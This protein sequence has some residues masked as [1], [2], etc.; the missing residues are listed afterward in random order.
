MGALGPTGDLGT[1]VDHPFIDFRSQFG[2]LRGRGTSLERTEKEKKVQ[3]PPKGPYTTNAGDTGINQPAI[4][5]SPIAKDDIIANPPIEGVRAQYRSWRDARPGTA[6]EKTWSIG[7]KGSSNSQGQVEK[8]ITEALA[9]KEPNNRS[10]KASHRLGFFKEGLPEDKSTT[11]ESKSKRPTVVT[12]GKLQQFQE[13]LTSRPSS[14]TSSR[15]PSERR[16]PI[17][18]PLSP[19]IL[20][21]RKGS[22]SPLNPTEGLATETAYFD[23]THTIET[24]SEEQLKLLPPQLLAEIRKHHNLTPGAAKG[25]SFSRSIPV[26]ASEKQKPQEQEDITGNIEHQEENDA[27]FSPVDQAQKSTDEDED[28]GEEQIS[29]ALF[30]PHHHGSPESLSDRLEGLSLRNDQSQIDTSSSQQ[31]LEEHDVPS[32]DIQDNYIS[33]QVKV[34]T[35]PPPSPGLPKSKSPYT[36]REFVFPTDTSVSN[37]E[38]DVYDDVGNWTASDDGGITDEDPDATPTASPK[39]GANQNNLDQHVHDHLKSKQPLE[40]IELI[41]YSHQ[42]GGHTTM[43]RFSKRAVC[44]QL[45]NE[46]NKFYEKIE[47]YHPQLLEFLPRYAMV[48][49]LPCHA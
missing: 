41:P 8:S 32:R 24:V 45:N 17:P 27:G 16:S 44:K 9:G 39:L 11:K 29:S 37:I 10:R 18:S 12:D 25:S 42:V 35:K 21:S 13:A 48:L 7:G 19:E 46:E 6:A 36:E 31:W 40:A 5:S 23:T 2:G 14:S 30:L 3:E 28:S 4:P 26:T 22:G 15:T 43:W 1:A 33:D 47:R 20:L 49:S 38:N 34:K